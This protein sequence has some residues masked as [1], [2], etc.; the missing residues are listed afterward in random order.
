M[1]Y[2]SET[3]NSVTK[4][5]LAISGIRSYLFQIILIAS[6]LILPSLAHLSGAPV[7]VFLPMHW[8]VIL[9]GLVYGWRSGLLIG[10]SAPLISFL[11]SG[12]PSPISLPSMMLELAAYGFITGFL[13]ERLGL[14]SFISIAVALILGRIIFIFS[15]IIFNTL[16]LS[17]NGYLKAA[18]LPG[19]VAAVCQIILLPFLAG[20]WIKKERKFIKDN[21]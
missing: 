20:F 2:Y 19:A 14:N 13:R 10:I 8:P 16:P 1:T 15:Q 5:T 11:L 3:I 4:P 21:Q 12:L 6:A 17:F 18:F 7:R 9:A